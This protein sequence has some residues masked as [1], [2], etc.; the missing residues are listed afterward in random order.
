MTNLISL[1]AEYKMELTERIVP[2]WLDHAPDREYG[3]HFSCLTGAGRV[4]DTDKFIWM[5]SRL[6]WTFSHLAGKSK[7]LLSD[8]IHLQCRK[9]AER[10]ALFLLEKGR[11]KEGDWFFSL[12]QK[13]NPL[14]AA[15][16]I[17]SDVFALTG[18]AEYAA[19]TGTVDAELQERALTAAEQTWTRILQRKDNPKGIY[20]KTVLGARQYRPLNWP[21]IILNTTQVLENTPLAQRIGSDLLRSM[22]FQAAADVLEYHFDMEG[23]VL[24]ERVAPDGTFINE[25]M[26]GRL[27]N[28]GHACET[29]GFI[30]EAL[31]K[32]GPDLEYYLERRQKVQENISLA[33]VDTVGMLISRMVEWNLIKGWDS[34]YGGIFYY[35]DALDLP[36][37][38]LE[39]TM[40]LWWVHVESAV[41]ALEAYKLSRMEPLRDWFEKIHSYMWEKFRRPENKEWYGYLSRQGVSTH[42]LA[43]GKWKGFFHLPRALMNM[44][45]IIETETKNSTN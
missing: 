41:A 29:L 6:V 8:S 23:Q 24:R 4:F 37:E 16:N 10:G 43:G 17:F 14:V 13:G 39:W 42:D 7:S 2:F 26:E 28:P 18:L 12:D 9:E 38:K 19:L 27:L 35:K 1:A 45:L 36:L 30:I 33:G 22:K 20:S 5:Q 40:K 32:D 3:G 21:M 31:Q 34:E 11:N 15:Y 44:I 25:N